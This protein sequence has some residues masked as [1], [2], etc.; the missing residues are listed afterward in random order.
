MSSV[1]FFW[2]NGEFAP[3]CGKRAAPVKAGADP[4]GFQLLED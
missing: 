1:F 3:Q 2:L 4:E